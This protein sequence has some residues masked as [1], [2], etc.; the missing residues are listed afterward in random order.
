MNVISKYELSPKTID[1]YSCGITL[2]VD[3][4][5]KTKVIIQCTI[6]IVNNT[7]WDIIDICHPE[8]QFNEIDNIYE[9][10]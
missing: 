10:Y 4:T 6:N 5:L 2:P 1:Y 8:R 3:S 7:K 9:I